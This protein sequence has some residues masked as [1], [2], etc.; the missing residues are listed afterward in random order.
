MNRLDAIMLGLSL[1]GAV[2]LWLGWWL[3]RAPSASTTRG[4]H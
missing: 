3:S 2:F 4:S 1:A